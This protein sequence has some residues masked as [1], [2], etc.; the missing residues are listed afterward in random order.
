MPFGPFPALATAGHGQQLRRRGVQ[1]VRAERLVQHAIRAH[2]AR[3]CFDP[4]GGDRAV[5]AHDDRADFGPSRAC[6]VA[7]LDPP[8]KRFL[9]A[10]KLLAGAAGGGAKSVGSSNH[11][12]ARARW[13]NSL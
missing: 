6:S 10:L 5:A 12:S 1:F 7:N 11:S 4:K 3:E 13:R 8:M 2:L 9:L